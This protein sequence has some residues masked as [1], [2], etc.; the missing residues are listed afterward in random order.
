MSGI[1]IGTYCYPRKPRKLNYYLAYIE[2]LTKY[3]NLK[4]NELATTTA[5]LSSENKKSYNC[6]G[7]RSF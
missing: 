3:I 4:K 7:K 5:N 6:N 1:K 2:L